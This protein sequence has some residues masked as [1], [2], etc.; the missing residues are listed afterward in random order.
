MQ[1][2]TFAE[3]LEMGGYGRFVWP[4]YGLSI[5]VL[6]GLLI[7]SVVRHRHLQKWLERSDRRRRRSRS[8]S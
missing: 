6:G 8:P 7:T 5:A 3:F 4:A 2:A 1:F